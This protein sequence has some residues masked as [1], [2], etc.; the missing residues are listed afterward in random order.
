M[1]ESVRRCACLYWALVEQSV[2]PWFLQGLFF[3]AVQPQEH[4]T[5]QSQVPTPL[6]SHLVQDSASM[7][8]L[9]ASSALA[10]M[11]NPPNGRGFRARS[12][13]IHSALDGKSHSSRS[14]AHRWQRAIF[15]APCPYQYR[16]GLRHMQQFSCTSPATLPSCS[17]RKDIL[18][19]VSTALWLDS[20]PR[21]PAAIN[22]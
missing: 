1:S 22:R 10:L 3:S 21:L 18:F 4:C 14:S 12:E 9:M 20:A 5:Q 8:V 7:D 11:P 17:T 13:A 2:V 19:S 15:C 16:V 6:A